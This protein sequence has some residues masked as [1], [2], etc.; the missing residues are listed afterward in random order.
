MGRAMSARHGSPAFRFA[1]ACLAGLLALAAAEAHAVTV[2]DA[3]GRSVNVKDSSRIVSVGGAITEIL[4]ALGLEKQI[5]AIDTTSHYP[6]R[7]FSEKPNVGYM[8]QLSAEGV[9][10]LNPTVVLAAE[11]AGPKET[12]AVLE[13]ATV[14]LVLV[15]ERYTGE[16]VIDKVKLIAHA[17]GAETGGAC[18]TA[19]IKHDLDA[20][21]QVRAR[22][23]RPL[24]VLFILSFMNGRPMVAGRNTAAEGIITMAGGINAIDD[25][26]GYKIVNDEAVIAV[27]PDVVL[28]MERYGST[29]TADMVFAHPAFKLTPAGAN[30]RFISMEGL[31]LL[32]FGPRTASAAR[33]LALA[34]YPEVERQR[35]P[36]E[37]AAPAA[38]CK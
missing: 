24:R 27:K 4:Y 23:G 16:G 34:L 21:E 6:P 10:G 26:E 12:V 8:R 5:V 13:A 17:T 33:D 28:A 19:R 15:P 25:Y 7:A 20:L 22:K 1:S 9:L 3:H 14:P 2:V 29:I 32:G 38:G 35:L 11:A 30:N 18:L 37:D 36:S 31:Y